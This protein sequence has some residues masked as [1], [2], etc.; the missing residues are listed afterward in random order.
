MLELLPG[1]VQD[2]GLHPSLKRLCA[3]V[4]G[5][6]HSEPTGF[7][8]PVPADDVSS[9]PPAILHLIDAYMHLLLSGSGFFAVG[10]IVPRLQRIDVGVQVLQGEDAAESSTAS[11]G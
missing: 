3:P 6:V 7:M 9:P 2:A 11:L 5:G 10:R 8:R 1:A 4:D